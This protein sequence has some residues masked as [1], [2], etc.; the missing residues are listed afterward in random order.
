MIATTKTDRFKVERLQEKIIELEELNALHLERICALHDDMREAV[1]IADELRERVE[2]LEACL[3]SVVSI[4]ETGF[5][6]PRIRDLI[7]ETV[8]PFEH[9]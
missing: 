8:K 4:V 1:T 6:G 5:D 3:L 7:I 2:E 9:E